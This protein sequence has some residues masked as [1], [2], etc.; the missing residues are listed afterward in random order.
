MNKAA[1]Y[2]IITD[3]EFQDADAQLEILH[4]YAKQHKLEVVNEFYEFPGHSVAIE[5]HTFEDLITEAKASNFDTV[6]V[7]S[8]DSIAD[9]AM[10]VHCV[11]DN[12]DFYNIKLLAT[13]DVASSHEGDTI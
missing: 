2:V 8:F 6:I 10:Y 1:L 3:T 7:E 13:D 4:A 11:I 5:H 9:D 12:L